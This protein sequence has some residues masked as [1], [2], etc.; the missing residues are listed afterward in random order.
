MKR[1]MAVGGLLAM[2]AIM[3]IAFMTAAETVV[4]QGRSYTSFGCC[5]PSDAKIYINGLTPVDSYKTCTNF[6][7]AVR[8]PCGN[9]LVSIEDLSGCRH[10]TFKN[11]P[12][13][14]FL[15]QKPWKIYPIS[16]GLP[17]GNYILKYV[18]EGCC[19]QKVGQY[20]FVVNG[21][22]ACNPL[23]KACGCSWC[24][25]CEC[26]PYINIVAILVAAIVLNGYCCW[27]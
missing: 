8:S 20:Q 7:I 19:W 18:L 15:A 26:S 17:P 21:P 10:W 2:M 11:D 9:A 12:S 23:P 3:A 6:E 13:D 16:Q 14:P 25:S 4:I 1:R 24:N 27:P 5:I 22:A